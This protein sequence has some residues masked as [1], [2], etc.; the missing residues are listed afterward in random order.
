[1]P[2]PVKLPDALIDE[3]R[4]AARREH[5]SLAGQ[6]EHW[7]ELGR[8]LEADLRS[9]EL[10]AELDRADRPSAGEGEGARLADVFASAMS[11][12]SRDAFANELAN[13]ATYGTDPAFP[14]W[15]VRVEPD[16]TCTPGRLVNREFVPAEALQPLPDAAG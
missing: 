7:A 13:R 16:G 11:K 10:R 8:V 6:I 4:D 14:G 9:G 12:N 1:M 3:A 15:L 2:Q 5:R